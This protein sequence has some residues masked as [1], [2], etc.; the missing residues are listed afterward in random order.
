MTEEIRRWHARWKHDNGWLR[1]RPENNKTSEDFRPV[2][3]TMKMKEKE[4]SDWRFTR[5]HVA[6]DAGFEPGGYGWKVKKRAELHETHSNVVAM[7]IECLQIMQ[8][9]LV[10]A[11][12]RYDSRKKN[13]G[14]I[15]KAF[16][17]KKM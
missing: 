8:R 1:G 4:G 9:S 15:S 11:K 14:C 17:L 3:R 2:L 12:S 13:Y 16:N 6:L 5:N 10:K 7:M